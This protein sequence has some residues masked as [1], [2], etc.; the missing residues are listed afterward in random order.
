MK[1]KV[2]A[3]NQFL[4]YIDGSVYLQSYESVV[5]CKSVGEMPILYKDWDYSRTTMKYVNK[6]L[7]DV[8]NK[9]ITKKDIDKMTEEGK[10]IIKN[11]TPNIWISGGASDYENQKGGSIMNLKTRKRISTLKQYH[12]IERNIKDGIRCLILWAIL[13][14]V[15]GNSYLN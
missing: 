13:M 10:I 6:F 12:A 2:I 3:K 9:H 8:F 15:A 4:I 7:S 1:I 14:I 5:A 11:D